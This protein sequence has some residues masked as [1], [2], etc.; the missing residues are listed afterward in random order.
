MRLCKARP[1]NAWAS[2]PPS[3][4]DKCLRTVFISLIVAPH[5]CSSSGVTCCLS[6]N[7]ID[8]TGA[9]ITEIPPDSKQRAI[10]SGPAERSNC[11]NPARTPRRRE[12][13]VIDTR[14]PGGV[15][16]DCLERP[17]GLGGH[18]DDSRHPA[19]PVLP[20]TPPRCAY[21]RSPPYPLQP[22]NSTRAHRDRPS[23]QARNHARQTKGAREDEQPRTAIQIACA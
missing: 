15:Q 4:C 21:G 12:P 11:R 13:W 2:L 17:N 18:I 14:W 23:T 8:S 1:L 5:A 7:E 22:P 10:S 19:R 9:G 20:V 16:S 6:S 3:I